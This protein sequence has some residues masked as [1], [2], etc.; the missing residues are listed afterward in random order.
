VGFAGFVGFVWPF[1]DAK[2]RRHWPGSEFSVYAGI[3]AVIVLIV[4]TLWE[5]LATA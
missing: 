5:A 3:V 4:L 2:I 1:I